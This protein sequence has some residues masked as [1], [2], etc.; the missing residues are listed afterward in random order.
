VV[1]LL[2]ATA[3]FTW[4]LLERPTQQGD[5]DYQT[6]QAA[7]APV[8]YA[9]LPTKGYAR[10]AGVIVVKD[11]D[12]QQIISTKTK[13]DPTP[14]LT[15]AW[16]DAAVPTE[17]LFVLA[18]LG[19]AKDVVTADVGRIFLSTLLGAVIQSVLVR[20]LYEGYMYKGAGGT[21]IHRLAAF[22]VMAS[23]WNGFSVWILVYKRY[24]ADNTFAHSLII[25]Y[26]A[27]TSVVPVC[28]WAIYFVLLDFGRPVGAS[29]L[30]FDLTN[31]LYNVTRASFHLSVLIRCIFLAVILANTGTEDQQGLSDLFFQFTG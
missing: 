19:L 13:S 12:G 22:T 16:S 26:V 29:V 10:P 25:A 24:S 28:L 6:M 5:E 18:V 4:N 3:Y 8:R 30:S 20:A 23:V 31:S 21:P 2:A 27:L 1:L 14:I 11:Q 15:Q 17:A 9:A 7:P